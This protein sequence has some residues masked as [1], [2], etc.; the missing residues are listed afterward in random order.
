MDS[1]IGRILPSIDEIWPDIGGCLSQAPKRSWKQPKTKNILFAL[2]YHFDFHYFR[3]L[4][5]VWYNFNKGSD[6]NLNSYLFNFRLDVGAWAEHK[7]QGTTHKERKQLKIA[8]EEFGRMD[9]NFGRIF[10]NIDN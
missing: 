6:V 3:F 10:L 1:N 7:K 9:S 4:F 8:R 5:Y 2:S